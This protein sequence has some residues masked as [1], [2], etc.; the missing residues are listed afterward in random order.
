MYY[1]YFPYAFAVSIF[2]FFDSSKQNVSRWWALPAFFAPVVTFYYF[3][4]TRAAKGIV[5]LLISVILLAAVGT[6]ETIIYSIEKEKAEFAKYSPVARQMIILSRKLKITTTDFDNAIEK[7]EQLSKIE[8]SRS[9]MAETMEFIRGTRVLILKNRDAVRRLKVFASDYSAV[10]KKENLLW[11]KNIAYYYNNKTIIQYD[12]SL[13]Y[14]LDSFETL[15]QY[16]FEN[17]NAIDGKS[18]VHLR[19]YDAYYMKYRRAVD[20][21]NILGVQR[22]QFQNRFLRQHPQ[23]KSYLPAIHHAGFLKLW[24]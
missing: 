8:S 13:D 22:I 9:S 5:P 19:N 17:F 6:G 11:M 7:L 16:T 21:H 10:L 15:L 2:I 3:I 12:T 1:I 14:Y 20:R 23:L 24:E 4:K 18:S